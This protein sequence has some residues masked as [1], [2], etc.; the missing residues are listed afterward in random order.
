MELY[1]K[2]YAEIN[3]TNIKENVEKI[4]KKYNNYQ[5]YFGIVKADCYGH[6]IKAVQKVIEGGAN[7][8]ATATLEEALSIRKN[9]KDIYH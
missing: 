7:Y 1:R 9:L 3:L 6:G 8:L 2:T 4:I 5:Y